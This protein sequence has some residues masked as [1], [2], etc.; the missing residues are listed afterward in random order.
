[1]IHVRYDGRSVDLDP[2]LLAL[3]DAPS[4]REIARALARHLDLPADHFDLHV[5]DRRPNG[6]VVVR[7]EA[8]YG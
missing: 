4:D 2:R 8:V 1:M 3:S 5:V 6:S 7:P